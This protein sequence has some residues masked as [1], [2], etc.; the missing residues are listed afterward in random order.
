MKDVTYEEIKEMVQA[1]IARFVNM[2]EAKNVLPGK[3]D[4]STNNKKLITE[5]D[6]LAATDIITVWPKT[7]I[8]PLARDT[9]K[10]RG[11]RFV[12][13]EQKKDDPAPPETKAET[14]T[15]A[16]GSDHGG[17]L[18]KEKLKVYLKEIGY[19]VHDAGC[20]SQEAVDYPDF[21][22]AVA[23]AVAR[24]ECRY[25]IMID[26]AGIGS[27]IVANKV[28]GVRAALCHDAYTANNSREHNDANVLTLGSMVVGEGLAKQIV[29][30]F[31][32][33]PFAGGR[34]QRRVNKIIEMDKK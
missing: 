1:A 20:M 2:P 4:L 14:K 27:A 28:P 32:E 21:A 12:T 6:V 33:T 31:L 17:F 15:V 24:H 25:G 26:G 13:I 18:L 10:S 7:I 5:K 11:I 30:I 9:A 19:Q 8:T 22:K 3:P 23:Q 34:H 29:K 16:L